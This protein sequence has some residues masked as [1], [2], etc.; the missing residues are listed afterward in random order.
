M[1]SFVL[2]F[3]GVVGSGA[4]RFV[5]YLY[6]KVFRLRNFNKKPLMQVQVAYAG[7]KECELRKDLNSFTLTKAFSTGSL[8]NGMPRADFQ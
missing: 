3:F 8:T 2:A 6:S 1:N 5:M 4:G 7:Y